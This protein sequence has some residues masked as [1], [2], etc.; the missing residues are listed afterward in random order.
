MN[1]KGNDT[2]NSKSFLFV[3][4]MECRDSIFNLFLK[5]CNYLEEHAK[6]QILPAGLIVFTE[7]VE[8]NTRE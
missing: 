5:T 1:L 2:K 6:E 7:L 8:C 3:M 4:Q